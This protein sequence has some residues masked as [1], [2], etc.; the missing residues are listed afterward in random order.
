ME[1]AC[2]SCGIQ[3]SGVLEQLISG[4]ITL[5]V[6]LI[7]AFITLSKR[8]KYQRDRDDRARRR[9]GRRR[10]AFQ[11]KLAALGEARGAA[12][13]VRN[14]GER[15]TLTGADLTRWLR[16]MREA[17]NALIDR[18]SKVS[19]AAGSL[20]DWQDRV[21]GLPYAHIQDAGQRRALRNL[22]GAI[23]KAEMVILIS[24]PQ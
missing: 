2:S 9:E 4:T 23:I 17:E 20:V 11:K 15:A 5:L 12:V 6:S 13:L 14:E 10:R 19:K 22:S 8:E 21:P 3:L 16:S 7:V 1:Q 18:A 24:Q